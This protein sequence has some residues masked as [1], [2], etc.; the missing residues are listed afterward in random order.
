MQ[1]S[2]SLLSHFEE[3][4]DKRIE[5]TKLH[6]LL[7]IIGLVLCAISAG[8]TTW[9]GIAEYGR[10]KEEFLRQHLPLP[11]G[12]PSHD[13]I[14]RVFSLLNTSQLATCMLHFTLEIME[15]KEKEINID[16]KYLRHSFDMPLDQKP[17]VMLNAWASTQKLALASVPVDLKSNE[18][19]AI[20]ILLRMLDLEGSIVSTDA[21]GCQV[22]IVSQI[23]SQK[24]DYLLALKGNQGTLHEDVKA[25]FEHS[26]AK[27]WEEVPHDVYHSENSEH[28]RN[29]YRRCTRVLLS[30][31]GDL[32]SDVISKW[33]GLSSI[34]RVES[35][36][37]VKKWVNGVLTPEKSVEY[38]YFISS[39]RRSA[40]SCLGIIRRHWGIENSLHY[41][42]DVSFN[43]DACRVRRGN[44]AANLSLMRHQSLNLLRKETTYKRSIKSKMQHC[45]RNDAYMLKVL[46]GGLCS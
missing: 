16:G 19:T 5:R 34:I 44:S 45:Q 41:V 30:D 2:V 39:L 14:A 22:Q 13:T 6:P 35:H 8:E 36:R 32:W 15:K 24:G 26:E 28:S 25:F 42:L 43:E 33:R 18:V 20:P 37:T 27:K 31:L 12:I 3:L 11:N 29:E 9:V 1:M 40:Q 21:M 23:I 10:D 38:R 46:Q 17:L 7:G 4:E